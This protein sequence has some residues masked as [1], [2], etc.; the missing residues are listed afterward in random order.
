MNLK[1][2]PKGAPSQSRVEK[3]LLEDPEQEQGGFCFGEKRA[4]GRDWSCRKG[5]ED[6]KIDSTL[7]RRGKDWNWGRRS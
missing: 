6:K 5:Q 7:G 2:R 1:R 3:G 4:E